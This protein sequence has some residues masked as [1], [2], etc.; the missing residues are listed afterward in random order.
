MFTPT[1]PDL[2]QMDEAELHMQLEVEKLRRVAAINELAEL[3]IENPSPADI[4]AWIGYSPAQ[5]RRASWDWL[6]LSTSL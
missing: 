6:V 3:G 1:Q 2:S 4:E 5:K